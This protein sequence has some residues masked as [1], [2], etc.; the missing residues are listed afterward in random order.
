MTDLRFTEIEKYIETS[1]QNVDF[2]IESI[3]TDL[4]ISRT[5]LH[6]ILKQ[7]TQ[8]ST[9]NYI[10]NI[11]LENGYLLLTDKDLTVGEISH[12]VGFKDPKYFNKL[13][14]RKY[15]V[16]PSWIRNGDYKAQ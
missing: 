14:K 8:M 4:G 1:S 11:R 6:R 3:C 13:F 5:T 7:Y 12:L 9:T 15:G 10:N 16:P 2:T